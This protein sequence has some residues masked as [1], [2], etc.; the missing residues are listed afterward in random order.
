MRHYK[1]FRDMINYVTEK[2]QHVN[3]YEFFEGNEIKKISYQKF[4]QEIKKLS[5]AICKR[6]PNKIHIGIIGDN[7]YEWALIYFSILY[8]GN[9]VVPIDKDMINKGLKNIINYSDVDILFVGQKQVEKVKNVKE[10]IPNVKEILMFDN[11]NQNEQDGLSGLME[12]KVDVEMPFHDIDTDALGVLLFT[13]GT[14][15]KSEGVMLSQ[16]NLLT[17]SR[18]YITFIAIPD[19]EKVLN[20]LPIHHSFALLCDLISSIGVGGT[21]CFS[22]G[23]RYLE[24]E[25]KIFKPYA[26]HAVPLI[27]NNLIVKVKMLSE[28]CVDETEKNNCTKD[29]FGGH[30]KYIACGGAYITKDITNLYNEVGIKLIRG[31]G[32]TECAPVVSVMGLEREYDYTT[33]GTVLSCNEVRIMDGEIQ[34]KGENVMI[35]YYKNLEKTQKAIADGWFSTGDI[36]YM[37]NDNLYIC[38][39]SKNIIILSNGKNVYPEEVEEIFSDYEDI[40][41]VV[42]FELKRS[43]SEGVLVAIMYTSQDIYNNKEA[44]QECVDKVNSVLPSFKKIRKYYVSENKLE[45]TSTNKIIRKKAIERGMKMEIENQIV[46]I[47]SKASHCNLE[48]ISLDTNMFLDLGLDSIT[49]TD[50]IVKCE[51]MFNISISDDRIVELTTVGDIVTLIDRKVHVNLQSI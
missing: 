5:S 39:R 4:G 41:E 27:A 35:G 47:L 3:A 48:D 14:T 32:I 9:V 24:E 21:V 17:D 20:V 43:D 44:I 50:I 18:A 15:G 51:T 11:L 25:I 49:L 1:D 8:S 38:G 36:G 29:F 22:R 30:L 28:K 37:K 16:H 33:I 42:V 34:V 26:M 31:Y 12:E 19:N 2:N 45:R 23:F 6:Y 10:K 40:L 7:C 13:S 46:K